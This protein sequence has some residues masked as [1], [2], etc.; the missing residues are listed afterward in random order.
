MFT[1]HSK[2]QRPRN[3]EMHRLLA[4]QHR[5]YPGQVHAKD[6]LKPPHFYPPHTGSNCTLGRLLFTGQ[7]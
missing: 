4:H 5:P 7:P 2:K 3:P 1:I 6:Y